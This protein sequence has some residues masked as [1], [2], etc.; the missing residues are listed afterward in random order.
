M[1]TAQDLHSTHLNI[2]QCIRDLGQLHPL[3]KALIS[4]Q[5]TLLYGELDAETDAY[6]RAFIQLGISRGTRT[7]LMA[8]PGPEFFILLFA[9]FKVGAVPVL[10]DPGMGLANLMQCYQTVQA[11]AFIGGLLPQALRL[12]H[13]RSLSSIGSVLFLGGGPS[14]G[15][16]RLNDRVRAARLDRTSRE[17]FPI[18]RTQPDDL[19][20]IQFTTGS[21]GPAKGAEYTHAM[22]AAMVR[23]ISGHY[24]EGPESVSCATLPLFALFDL[25]IGATAVLPHSQFAH[26]AKADPGEILRAINTFHITHL[27]A[28]PTL[29]KRL[30]DFAQN[31]AIQLPALQHVVAG[32][33]PYSLEIFSP[34][35]NLLSDGAEIHSTYGAT[36][37]LPI[38]SLS[39]RKSDHARMIRLQARYHQGEGTCVGRALPGGQIRLIPITEDSLPTWSDALSCPLGEI[40]EIIV[41]GPHV[42]QRY[43]HSPEANRLYKIREDLAAGADRTWHRTG[44]LGWIDPEGLLWFCGRK[45]QRVISRQHI[46]HTVQYEGIFNAHPEVHRCA[47]VGIGSPSQQEPVLCVELKQHPQAGRSHYQHQLKNELQHLFP[48][49]HSEKQPP[50]HR[51]LFHPQLPVDSR[52]QAKINRPALARWA[53]R[54]LNPRRSIFG[55]QGPYRWLM[56]IPILGWGYFIFGLIWPFENPLLQTIWWA[57]LILSAGVH[58]LQW[59]Y[60]LP[61]ARTS[62][63]NPKLALLLTFIFGATWWKSLEISES[64]SAFM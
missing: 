64:K 62:G 6:A 22:A 12:L 9:L 19:L 40:G 27:F 4:P 23:Q 1:K 58:T 25:L 34:F 45:S 55:V 60:A 26:P 50:I 38:S 54:K 47:L 56:L 57:D 51:F 35:L 16:P 24:Q 2:A 52:H 28:S 13:R 21:T 63:F 17:P 29:L 11:E 61:I 42:S 33:A 7:I 15:I 32:G 41:S 14:F 53:H 10:A 36:E 48:P 3:K 44:D 30:G 37:A 49:V 31:H 20:I 5:K 18:A 46:L 8:Q 43:H 59:V 39:L